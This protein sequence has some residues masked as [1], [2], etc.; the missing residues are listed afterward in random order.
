MPE[1]NKDITVTIGV[2]AYNEEANIK[3][4]L[5]SLIRVREDG[6]V[7]KEIFIISDGSTDKTSAIVASFK[8]ERIRLIDSPERKGK[9]ARINEV[10]S[11]AGSDI[12]VILDAD[13]R[14]SSPDVI[15]D[16]I[17]PIIE[18]RAVY[19]S[20]LAFP[21]PPKTFV[22]K[23]AFTGVGIWNDLRKSKYASPLYFSEGSVRAF[24]KTLYKEMKFPETSAD[25]VFP[26]L[27]CEQK[28]YAFVSAEKALVHYKLP[29][30][31]S[32]Y[33][34]QYKRFIKSK[35]IQ[36]LS[37]D[38]EFVE[39][40]YTI[41]LEAK[42]VYLARRMIKNPF[43]TVLYLGMVPL[44][45][46]LCM[47]DKDRT[48]ARW[49]PISSS[50]KIEVGERKKI[51]IISSYDSIGNPYYNG[52]GALVVH[53]VARRLADRFDVKIICG[54]YPGAKKR[55]IDGVCYE[56]AGFSFFGPKLSQLIFQASLPY[57]V[58]AG[59]FDVWVESFMPPFST[60]FLS[61]FTKKPVIGM[62]HMLAGEDMRRKYKL[63]FHIIE[64]M[65]VKMCRN[66]IVSTR[67]S[68][69][70]IRE[71]NP[72]ALIEVI[73]NGVEID[74][75]QG[76]P[77]KKHFLYMGRLE[78]DQKGLDLLLEAYSSIAQKTEFSLVIAGGGPQSEKE[79]L[80]KMV[81]ELGI[82][83]KVKLLGR[84]DGQKKNDAFREAIAVVIPSRFETFSLTA[85][86]A[87]AH[88]VPVVSFDIEGLR[89]LP[90]DFSC[91]AEP[92]DAMAMAKIMQE[93]SVQGGERKINIEKLKVFLKDYNWD[94]IAGR[95]GKHIDDVLGYRDKGSDVN[96]IIEEII[97]KRTPC[98]FISPH[99][100]DAILSSGALL[101]RLATKTETTVVTIFT[102]A[103]L[104]P[105]TFS[106]GVN[107][108]I[109]GGYKNAQDLFCLRKS[110]DVEACKSIGAKHIH[111]GF[112][113][114]SFRKKKNGSPILKIIGRFLPEVVHVYPTYQFDII[115][116]KISKN[117]A[118]TFAMIEK[119]LRYFK[120]RA[121]NCV[122]F[123]PLGIGGNVDHVMV[124][125]IC[126]KV[127]PKVVFW[128]DF[129]YNLRA[130]VKVGLA[131]VSSLGSLD[132]SGLEDK[133]K[134]LISFYK[135]Q[136]RP[137]FP[138]G[139]VL[140]PEN[141][142]SADSNANRFPEVP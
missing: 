81:R 135:S 47:I 85:L 74:L 87:L 9:P 7:I 37:Y 103:P 120:K 30:T 93:L 133:K 109:C 127:F 72:H 26:F 44:V 117:D 49:E 55:R 115:S 53:E 10:F 99:L 94:N 116:G 75:A 62:V 21:L 39:K 110:E 90:G 125:E 2:P 50:K 124:R 71:I 76:R 102:E 134:R 54:N 59:D 33:L 22:Q 131:P 34:K 105:Y 23:I 6:F 5:D 139:I 118:H 61:V 24:G 106:T 128:E 57:Y 56:Y 96:S 83:E 130:K 73:P 43:W 38:K 137:M 141:Y 27:Y 11:V 80:V 12:V 95:Y 1:N 108:K 132:I 88:G 122:V 66:F 111:L 113:D 35:G 29:E 136:I 77:V 64:N 41:G 31:L 114:A 104:P 16:L 82:A 32:D 112:Q 138:D 126:R 18:G 15:K 42:A 84:V 70:R 46:I 129:P 107:L 140:K 8:D 97:S 13:I 51:M 40:Y 36:E 121:G 78:I 4:L 65:G 67:E 45:R 20:G 14:L 119:K 98:V 91:K 52:G 89:W 92:F 142:H 79:R 101:L 3:E 60:A 69:Q 123:C 58:I 48:E 68:G 28:K 100:D 19:S 25:D 17:R 63:P 86:E